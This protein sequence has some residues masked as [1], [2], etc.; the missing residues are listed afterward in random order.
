MVD[1]FRFSYKHCREIDLN[2]RTPCSIDIDTLP[3]EYGEDGGETRARSVTFKLLA[4]HLRS[5]RLRVAT[6]WGVCASRCP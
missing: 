5:I 6:C 1:A 4:A 3:S 2:I